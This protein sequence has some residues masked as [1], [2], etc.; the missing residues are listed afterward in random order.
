MTNWT[1][2]GDF[3]AAEGQY[4]FVKKTGARFG[5]ACGTAVPLFEFE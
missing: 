5:N 1:P 4:R 2:L 3:A